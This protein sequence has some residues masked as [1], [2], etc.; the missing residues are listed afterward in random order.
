MSATSKNKKID[1]SRC[2]IT[3][4]ELERQD[5]SL[6]IRLLKKRKKSKVRSH[7]HK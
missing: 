2:I 6:L 3:A 5:L 7:W 1:F 4:A